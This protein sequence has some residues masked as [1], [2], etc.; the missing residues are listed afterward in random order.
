MTWLNSCRNRNCPNCQALLKELWIDARKA[1]VIDAPYFH[2]VFTISAHLNALV[3]AN[4]AR[5]IFCRKLLFLS[6]LNMIFHLGIIPQTAQKRKD[7]FYYDHGNQFPT[8][9]INGV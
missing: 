1:E 8:N 7:G 5:F 2:V 6:A 3:Y 9:E 4:Q